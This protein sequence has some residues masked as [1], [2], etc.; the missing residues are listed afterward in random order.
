M[1]IKMA[2]IVLA[3][4]VVASTGFGFVKGAVQQRKINREAAK[5]A[6]VPVESAKAGEDEAKKAAE[7]AKKIEETEK[8]KAEEKAQREKEKR[9]AEFKRPKRLGDETEDAD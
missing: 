3:I 2:L 9:M 4:I 1:S 5:N 7:K 6:P 8:R